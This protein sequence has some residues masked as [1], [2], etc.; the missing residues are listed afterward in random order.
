MR[1]RGRNGGTW[2]PWHSARRGAPALKAQKGP[3]GALL[4]ATPQGRKL[5]SSHH[6]K[7]TKTFM[8]IKS[9]KEKSP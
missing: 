4:G 6:E 5:R 3:A 7:I 8:L 2:R 9:T 1:K